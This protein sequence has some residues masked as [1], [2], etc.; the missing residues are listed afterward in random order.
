[1]PHPL[2]FLRSKVSSRSKDTT[3]RMGKVELSHYH[4]SNGGRSQSRIHP[5]MGDSASMPD[6]KVSSGLEASLD[7]LC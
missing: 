6:L 3:R 5:N 1:M 4:D 2:P 7:Q